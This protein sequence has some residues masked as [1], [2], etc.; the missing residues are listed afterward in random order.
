M[1]KVFKAVGNVVSGVVKAVGSVVSGVVKAV[2]NIASSVIN[3]V[4]SP[5]LGLFGGPEVPSVD[6]GSNSPQGALITR[7]GTV[8]DVN[9]VY[10]VRKIGGN[11]VFA[12]TGGE[13][14]KYLWVAYALCEGGIEGLR[15]VWINDEQI[16]AGD[17]TA[18]NSGQAADVTEG[19]SKCKFAG[20]AR[21]QFWKGL[22]FDNPSYTNVG[23]V[24]SQDIFAGAP[25][26]DANMNYNGVATLFVRYEWKNTTDANGQTTNPFS[27]QIPTIGV[28]ILGK[29]VADLTTGTPESYTYGGTGYTHR[30]SNN[31]AECLLDY[32]RNPRYGKGLTNDEIDWASWKQAALKCQT[33]VTYSSE[34]TQT[35]PILTMN[36]I[37]GTGATLFNNVQDMLKQ[38][39]AY[40]PY[41]Q[42]KF[43]LLIEDGGNPTDI[44]SS[45]YN[46]AAT[47]DK[48]NIQGDLTYT[49]IERTSKY[50]VVTVSYVDPDQ[51]WTEQQVVYPESE[52]D[53][54][55]YKNLDGG[56][57]NK[58]DEKFTGITNPN[59][60]K[61]FAKMIFMKS[62]EQD[63]ITLTVGSQGFELDVGDIVYIDANILKFGTTPGGNTIGWRVISIKM[64]NDYTFTLGCVR[65]IPTIYP[66]VRTGGMVYKVKLH[67]PKGTSYVYPKEPGSVPAALQNY[68]GAVS[69]GT[70]PSGWSSIWTSTTG[71]T[72]TN[73]FDIVPQ[74]DATAVPT[75]TVSIFKAAFFNVNGQIYC[76]LYFRQPTHA[77]YDKTTF[78]YKRDIA[79]E[80]GYVQI[81]NSTKSG[82][83]SIQVQRIGPLLVNQVYV[84]KTAVKYSTGD[85]SFKINTIKIT[86]TESNSELD[87]A[88]FI[89]SVASGWTLPD[90]TL[91]NNK[92][93]I[94][95][96]ITGTPVL[97]GGN[98]TT[99]RGLVISVLQDI[100]TYG[101]NTYVNGI[102]IFYKASSATYWKQYNWTFG[103]GYSAG[104][105]SPNVTIS[106]FGA[107]S[108]PSEPSSGQLYD[109]VFRYNYTDNL[110][111]E[112]QYRAMQVPVEKVGGSYVFNAFAN[113]LS[114]IKAEKIASQII[115]TEAN[116]PQSAVSNALNIVVGIRAIYERSAYD[117]SNTIRMFFQPPAGVDIP[118]W[119]GVTIYYRKIEVGINTGYTE[120]K[121][122][123]VTLSTSGEYSVVI[124]RIEYNTYDYEFGI[125]CRVLVSGV[126]QN[127]TYAMYGRGRFS[128]LGQNINQ[129]IVFEQRYLSDVLKDLST[130]PS[131]PQPVP[132]VLEWKRVFTQPQDGSKQ[133]YRYNYYQLKLQVPLTSFNNLI[134]YRREL[135]PAGAFPNVARYNGIGRWEKITVGSGTSPSGVGLT[136]DPTTGITTINMRGPLGSKEFDP[137]YEVLPG[138]T[139]LNPT[140]A[141]SNKPEAA[142]DTHEFV[143]QIEKTGAV[144][145][146]YVVRLP[147]IKRVANTGTIDGFTQGNPSKETYDSFNTAYLSGYSRKLTDARTCETNLQIYE[148]TGYVNITRL[149]L[150]GGSSS[151]Q[152][153]PS[154]GSQVI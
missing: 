52:A 151:T 40:M 132:V 72:T 36:Y 86:P 96:T 31:P 35:G 114:T 73:P 78:Y 148:G 88:D 128:E 118:S 9:V 117:G 123:P 56:R 34:S 133:N 48:T 84:V 63:S 139:L 13:G 109:F 143:L 45:S 106:D 60:A 124:P 127:A 42:G 92:L 30:Y 105:T 12:E 14:N 135:G 136:I 51:K 64:N 46:V 47:F 53:R 24:I 97:T 107:P 147:I 146:S 62:R 49:G 58:R 21:I 2:G 138:R 110:V 5:F 76:D 91:S 27:G 69:T 130:A 112:Y 83:N 121:A 55:Y 65:H 134:I 102:T 87:P 18:L 150:P 33:P 98:P 113:A 44:T 38:F 1:S 101:R 19:S 79:S 3:F 75:D 80:T 116:A 100:D 15:E 57:E 17:I 4:A 6:T 144:L 125:N 50:S 149:Y 95:K 68:T 7:D 142:V 108:Y 81:D 145:S 67:V 152:T 111:S 90:V 59:V 28:V 131:D 129:M 93:A 26:W 85:T 11:I 61:A 66:Y 122:W 29:T 104:I 23:S 153:G 137:Y 71:N 74:P 126:Q 37:V 99:P 32:L 10:G 77:M 16:P 70:T 141:S 41:V 39:R 119:V 22:Y 82:A 115:T 89:E 8:A 25:N 54:T 103:G 20:R 94:I 43:K 120:L 154:T 140:F